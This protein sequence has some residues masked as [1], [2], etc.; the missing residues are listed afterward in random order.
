MADLK[1]T[2]F[3]NLARSTSGDYFMS[4]RVRGRLIRRSLKTN[5]LEAAQKKLAEQLEDERAKASAIRNGN[6]LVGDAFAAYLAESRINP[7][8]TQRTKDYHAE[9]VTYIKRNWPLCD[10][11]P[12]CKVSR[13]E[14]A[15]VAE[16]LREKYSP[17]RFNGMLQTLN[18][19]FEIVQDAGGRRDNPFAKIHRASVKVVEPTLPSSEQVEKLL[20]VLDTKRGLAATLVRFLMYS[21]ARIDEARNVLWSDVDFSKGEIFLRKTKRDN[22]RRVPM[23]AEMR[24]L[25]EGLQKYTGPDGP[26]VPIMGAP[27]VIKAGCEQAGIPHMSHHD[28]RHLFA[29][30]CIESGVDILTAALWLGH[31][32]K[33]ALLMKIYGHLRDDHSRAMAAKVSFGGNS[34]GLRKQGFSDLK[35]ENPQPPPI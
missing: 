20:A 7:K 31:R 32:D 24:E 17:S 19:T 30:R 5:Q 2:R 25:L 35:S 10:A 6:M 11:V 22:P 26:V 21:G 14:C 16:R 12:A 8:A 33:G 13:E 18:R 4:A 23:I 15:A 3:A 9:C 1:R 29:T 28:F 27:G 34:A